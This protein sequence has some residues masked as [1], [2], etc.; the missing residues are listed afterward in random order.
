MGV[1][2]LIPVDMFHILDT[3]PMLS[4]IAKFVATL[5]LLVARSWIYFPCMAMLLLAFVQFVVTAKQAASLHT[6]YSGLP[7]V[8]LMPTVA[9]QAASIPVTSTILDVV[10]FEVARFV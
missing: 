1:Q 7:P 5:A 4:V 9:L 10:R 6:R 2:P 8:P 3:G